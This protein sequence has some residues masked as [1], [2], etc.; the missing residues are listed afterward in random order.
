MIKHSKQNWAVGSTVKVGFMSLIVKAA[1]ATPGDYMPDAYILT[2]ID[3]TKVYRFV[4]HN[5]LA[6]ITID[7]A[8]EMLEEGK[9]VAVAAANAA[10]ARASAQTA[11]KALFDWTM[12]EA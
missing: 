8:R 11:V 1:V 3:G 9:R 10:I 7:E 6:C 12:V 2:N 4:P 5:G